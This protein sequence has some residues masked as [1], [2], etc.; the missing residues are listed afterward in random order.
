MKHTMTTLGALMAWTTPAIAAGGTET[1]ETS[2]ITILL[3][4][5]GSLIV[6]GQLIPGLIIFCGILR[7]LFGDTAR[8]PLYRFYPTCSE[9]AVTAIRRHGPLK[10]L[11]FSARRI[12]GYF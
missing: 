6:V 5:F 12:L 7:G 4:G 11:F 10:G 3:L 9:Y 1:T 2:L 8:K